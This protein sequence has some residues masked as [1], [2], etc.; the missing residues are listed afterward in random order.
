MLWWTYFSNE[1]QKIIKSN[2]KITIRTDE[3]LVHALPPVFS[4]LRFNCSPTHGCVCLHRR[5]LSNRLREH[6]LDPWFWCCAFHGICWFQC[7]FVSTIHVWS[8]SISPAAPSLRS[9]AVAHLWQFVRIALRQSDENIYGRRL[10]FSMC[11]SRFWNIHKKIIRAE[12]E[13]KVCN[14]K[15]QPDGMGWGYVDS[16]YSLVLF[17]IQFQS[18]YVVHDVSLF[19]PQDLH[20]VE[21]SWIFLIWFCCFDCHCKLILVSRQHYW[22]RNIEKYKN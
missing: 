7:L 6:R 11:L 22:K 19:V 1:K 9:I 3:S 15:N 12:N 17:Q 20:V 13:K 5:P 21:D 14:K 18:G 2:R 8:Q 10:L 4:R 16:G